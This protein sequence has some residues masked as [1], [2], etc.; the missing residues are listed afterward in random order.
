VSVCP[1]A[2]ALNETQSCFRIVL[3]L[4]IAVL[5]YDWE[6]EKDIDEA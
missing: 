4:L 2:S 1:F 6:G 3:C 5:I